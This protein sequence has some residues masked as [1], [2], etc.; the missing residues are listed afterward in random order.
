MRSKPWVK[1]HFS[2]ICTQ[3][4]IIIILFITIIIIII[5]IIIFI[6]IIIIVFIIYY[7]YYF[8]YYSCF[9]QY[10]VSEWSSKFS[11]KKET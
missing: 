1:S 8:Y 4:G 9:H 5:I 11:R 2:R 6:I 3:N 10:R 7:Y